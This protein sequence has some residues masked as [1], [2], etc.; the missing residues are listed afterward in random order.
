MLLGRDAELDGCRALL[1]RAASGNGGSLVVRGEAGVGKSALL[2]SVVDQSEGFQVLRTQGIESESPLAYAALHRLLLPLLNDLDQ[3]PDPQA[4]A[5]RGVFGLGA[6]SDAESGNERFL[7]FLAALGLV[8]HAAEGAPVLCVV[9]DAHWLDD[10]SAA[11]LLFIAR[12]V[13]FEPIFVL[14]G[15]REGGERRFDPAELPDLRLQGLG[16]DAARDLLRSSV[17]VDVPTAVRDELLERTAGNP[18][19]LIEIPRALS[20]DQMAGTEP[21]PSHLPLTDGLERVFLE[22]Y[23][24][25]PGGAQSY[26]LVAAADDSREIAVIDRAARELGLGDEA[27]A[28][29]E[30]SELARVDGT[31]LDLRHPLVR[32]AIYSSAPRPDRRRVHR[33]LAQVFSE[34]GELDRPAWHRAAA[35]DTVDEELAEELSSVAARARSGGAHEAASA[36]WERAAELSP[37]ASARAQLLHEAAAAA[38]MSGQPDRARAL[39]QTARLLSVDTLLTADIDRLRALVEMNFGSAKVAHAI[40]LRAAADVVGVDPAR[41]RQMAMIAAALGVFGAHSG[42]AIDP[43]ELIPAA[44]EDGDSHDVTFGALLTGMDLLGRGRLE[45][46]AV[47]LRRALIVGEGLR[48]P[49]LLTNMPIAAVH[50]GDDEASRRWY[51]IELSEARQSESPFAV[52]H[53]LTRRMIPDFVTG[54][55]NDLAA[56]AAESESLAETTG[57]SNQRT[58]PRAVLLLL[59]TYRGSGPSDGELDQLEHHAADNPAGVLDVL[60]QDVLAWTRGV[61]A[62]I[63]SRPEEALHHFNRIVQPQTAFAAAVDHMDAA[64]QA[65]HPDVLERVVAR[66]EEFGSA[67]GAAWAVA[68]AEHGRALGSEGA[69]AEE[70]FRTA[71]EVGASTMRPLQRARTELAFGE[72]LRRA[73][74]RVDSRTHLRAALVAFEELGAA[75]WADRAAEELRASGEAS[76]RREASP[77]AAM[78]PQE[79][80]VA[81]LVQQG[82]SNREVAARLFVSPRTVDFHLRN[83]F[84]KLGISSRGGLLQVDLDSAA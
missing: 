18:L 32:S 60:I 70:H 20:A 22:R 12:R 82:L 74:R 66:A 14:F 44:S 21:L 84:S 78:T 17:G 48:S 39:A 5:L 43:L 79:L 1:A 26:L 37:S 16:P 30:R 33:A 10:A 3:L 29:A 13:Q 23:R 6:W 52:L 62:L 19:A 69:A 73:R 25:L 61:R 72:F 50:L 81:R 56:A 40:L 59:K 64:V 15:A 83:V 55:W 53:A 4:Q 80:Q 58:F 41:A 27:R 67:T 31:V 71:L 51:D 65:R 8:A 45:Q 36:A 68:L 57:S 11:A 9:D 34:R 76:R 42:V 77:P 75:S 2:Q 24:R 7:V 47:H 46:A 28:D 38:W 54:R 49:D 63:S 35:A